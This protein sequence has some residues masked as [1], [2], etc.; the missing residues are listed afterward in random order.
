LAQSFATD[1]EMMHDSLEFI[2]AIGDGEW[3]AVDKFLC[4]RV[5]L[6]LQGDNGDTALMISIVKRHE[7]LVRFLLQQAVD[8]D[9][10]D[11][12]GRTALHLACYFDEKRLV[13]CLLFVG[14]NVHKLTREG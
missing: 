3:S 13:Q 8:V 2:R 10:S 5:D 1:A 9:T 12:T 6:D 14:A 4:F 7:E 11:D